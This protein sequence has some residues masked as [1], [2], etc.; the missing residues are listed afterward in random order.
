MTENI[1]RRPAIKDTGMLVLATLLITIAHVV[2]RMAKSA[3]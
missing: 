2:L 1:G 3:D